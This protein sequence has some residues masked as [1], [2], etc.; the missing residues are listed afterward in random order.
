MPQSN[1]LSPDLLHPSWRPW[2][3]AEFEK[4]HFQKLKAFLI[5]EASEG[6]L[7]YPEEANIL[8][9]FTATP[10]EA[11]KIVILGQDP[12]H[13]QLNGTPQAHGL[14]FSVPDGQRLPPSLRNIF[15]ELATDLSEPSVSQR[16]SG[17]LS[18]WAEQ[19]VLLLNAVLTVR[20]GEAGSHQNQGWETFTAQAIS[21]LNEHIE[22][23]VFVLWGRYAQAKAS[24]IDESK[25]LILK[26][27][28][29]SPLSAYNGF[30]GSRP[31]SKANHY[32]QA[33]GKAPIVW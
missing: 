10:F 7:V 30:F 22:G 11:V 15:K 24:L 3:E 8:G 5:S 28:H 20:A 9:A 26:S 27:A 17:D 31:F 16:Q 23:L 25:H 21:A 1:F 6:K 33:Q 18:A 2:L 32:L 4:P 19:G 14:S 13:G 29:P 12:Y